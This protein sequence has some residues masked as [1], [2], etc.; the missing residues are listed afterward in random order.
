[1]DELRGEDRSPAAGRKLLRAP[2]NVRLLDETE[3]VGV[4]EP[5]T[6][7]L[8]PGCCRIRVRC[9]LGIPVQL[10]RRP[11]DTRVIR[12]DDVCGIV[13]YSDK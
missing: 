6:E 7:V 2:R 13:V 10:I 4:F 12:P 11:R 5:S 9:A 8:K 3:V 1:M